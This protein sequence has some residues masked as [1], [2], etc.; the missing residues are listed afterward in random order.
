MWK[1]PNDAHSV[2][3]SIGMLSAQRR[4]KRLEMATQEKKPYFTIVVKGQHQDPEAAR[5]G[6]FLLLGMSDSM[7]SLS[8]D[9]GKV[10]GKE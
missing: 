9:Y 4:K 8:K 10:V 5:K 6:C 3:P 7:R 1:F 2:N